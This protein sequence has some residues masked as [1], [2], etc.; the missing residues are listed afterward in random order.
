MNS[1]ELSATTTAIPTPIRLDIRVPKTR[2]AT[3]NTA[4]LASGNHVLVVKKLHPAVVNA[5]RASTKRKIRMATMSTRTKIPP[6]PTMIRARLSPFPAPPCRNRSWSG[7][8]GSRTLIDHL[9]TA[10][11]R[12]GTDVS[13]R[14]PAPRVSAE[15]RRLR[16][17]GAGHVGGHGR[18]REL[19][20]R[21]VARCYGVLDG[22]LEQ[23]AHR[24]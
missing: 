1:A 21:R 4:G 3:P 8:S 23:G 2:A 24:R 16:R 15:A 5:G 18:V 22:V 9:S 12:G 19:V 10:R 6:A 17:A 14:R 7:I 13:P 20:G 11:R